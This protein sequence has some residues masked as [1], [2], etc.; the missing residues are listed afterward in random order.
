MS[1]VPLPRTV[2]GCASWSGLR[3]QRLLRDAAL[4]PQRLQLPRVDAMAFALEALLHDA[5]EGEV[6]VVAAE[7]DVIADR[8]ALEREVAV[9]LADEDQAE[10]G[11]AAADVAHEQQVAD[12]ELPPPALARAVDP[13]VAGGLRLLEQ[14]H[15]REA[16]V[17]RGPQRQL[18]RLFVERCGHGDE[19]V[20]AVERERRLVPQRSARPT[21]A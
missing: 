4:V 12:A 19:H 2:T 5:R 9:V 6:H 1:R 7:Q 17:G 13:R 21:P 8:D 18:A 11:R 14:R 10:V 15:A 3:E 20:L 16:G